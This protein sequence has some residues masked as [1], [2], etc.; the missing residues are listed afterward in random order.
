MSK[1]VKNSLI[2]ALVL[3]LIGASI[4]TTYFLTIKYIKPVEELE[5]VT[6][7]NLSF[8]YAKTAEK[9]IPSS[10]IVRTPSSQGSGVVVGENLV[11]TND[12]VVGFITSVDIVVIDEND[13][14]SVY[15]GKVLPE[16]VHSKYS[17]IDL[18][19][20]QIIGSGLP[21]FNQPVTLGHINSVDFGT[22][23]LMVGNPRGIGLLASKAMISNPKLGIATEQDGQEFDY[24]AI[25]A[26]VNS[27]N[28]GGGL[29]NLRG[30]LIGIVTL[31][32]KS[33]ETDNSD[34]VFGIGFALRIDDI[35]EYLNRYSVFTEQL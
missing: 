30:E 12:H 24:Y 31:R 21:D 17:E 26:P 32:Q 35:T 9:V 27:G 1:M 11:L 14:F 16:P 15:K 22:S 10:V 6:V 34:A 23:A 18:A 33:D 8:A 3:V 28:S 20:V 13:K 5:S 19:L 29:Y 7:E 2:S 25:D 4:L